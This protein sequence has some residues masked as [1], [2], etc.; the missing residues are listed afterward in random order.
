[1]QTPTS[2]VQNAYTETAS[3]L[4]L[5]I[6]Y[7]ATVNTPANGVI[8]C[9][10]VYNRPLSLTEVNQNFNVQRSRFGL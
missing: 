1:L 3:N 7:G 9:A 4:R 2:S 10:R 5:A 8:A 6:L